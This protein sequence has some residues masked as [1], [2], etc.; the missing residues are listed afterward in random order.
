MTQFTN[1]SKRS[2]SNIRSTRRQQFFERLSL[3]SRRSGRPTCEK[4][5]YYLTSFQL[6]AVC[7]LGLEHL[8]CWKLR[9]WLQ[10]LDSNGWC[11]LIS[12]VNAMLYRFL[13]VF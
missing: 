10:K 8:Y 5:A 6:V 12:M 7:G 13:L 4:L 9:G 3:I 1:F 11:G 2:D